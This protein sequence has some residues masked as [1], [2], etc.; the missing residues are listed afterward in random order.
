VAAIGLILFSQ[1]HSLLAI[2]FVGLLGMLALI[3]ASWAA[4]WLMGGKAAATQRA[5][6]VT[7]TLRNI[8]VGLVI[9]GQNFAGTPAVTAVVAYGLLS[10]LATLLLALRLGA[11]KQTAAPAI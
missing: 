7:T 10:L 1:L 8:S 4:G 2:R 11:L 3:L 9:V 6:A 5:M